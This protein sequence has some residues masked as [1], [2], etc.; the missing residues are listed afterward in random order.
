MSDRTAIAEYGDLARRV[1]L[2]PREIDS[3]VRLLNE[4]DAPVLVIE[5]WL[6][7]KKDLHAT[8]NE[9]R[10][11]SVSVLDET[12]KAWRV[13]TGDESDWI[14]KSQSEL[15]ER[16]AGVE[17]IPTPTKTLSEFGGGSA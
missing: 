9:R 15:L 16:Q 8:E 2:S 3:V 13:A 6:C 4:T 12:P 7:E 1:D 14:P 5:E 11:Y 10:V 17:E